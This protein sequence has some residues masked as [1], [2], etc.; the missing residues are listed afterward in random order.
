MLV[1]DQSTSCQTTTSCD[2]ALTGIVINSDES[3]FGLVWRLRIRV[4][5]EC[6]HV[7]HLIK[8]KIWLCMVGFRHDDDITVHAALHGSKHFNRELGFNDKKAG[9][10]HLGRHRLHR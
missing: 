5:R 8:L 1:A 7:I 6:L 2:D 9:S 4:I 10:Y 3:V